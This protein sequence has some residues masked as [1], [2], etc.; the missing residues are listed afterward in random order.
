[1]KKIYFNK[2]L[3]DPEVMIGKPVFK[4]TRIPVYIILD[5]IGDGISEGKILEIY[6]DLTGED[7]KA[8]IK[9]ASLMMDRRVLY[10]TA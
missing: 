1:M 9:F 5:L 2:I 3:V 10:E 6:P 7:I 8:A 4:G